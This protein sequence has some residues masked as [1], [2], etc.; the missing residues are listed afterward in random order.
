MKSL[1]EDA[2]L[3]RREDGTRYE[4]GLYRL[5]LGPY[6]KQVVAHML[7]EVIEK[8]IGVLSR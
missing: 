1:G 2:L 4:V 8:L 3:T 5:D 7:L 6:I